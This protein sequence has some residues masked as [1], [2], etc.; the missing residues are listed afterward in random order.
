MG[1]GSMVHSKKTHF[2]ILM[3]LLR[4]NL[5]V[6]EGN[7]DR[8]FQYLDT[9][10]EEGGNRGRVHVKEFDWGADEDEIRAELS[11]PF[12]FVIGTIPISYFARQMLTHSFT[13]SDLAYEAESIPFLVRAMLMMASPESVIL[14]A[15]EFRN[16]NIDTQL[17]SALREAFILSVVPQSDLHPGEL[18]LCTHSFRNNETFFVVFRAEEIKIL[19]LKKK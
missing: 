12:D 5:D 16:E 11:P 2:E 6:M 9:T 18:P 3:P 13:G 4:D 19:S 14:L 17:V 10:T 8:N 15:Q 1:N 7:V